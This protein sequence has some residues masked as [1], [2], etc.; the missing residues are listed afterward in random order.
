MN[1]SASYYLTEVLG[2]RWAALASSG[3][4]SSNAAPDLVT[5]SGSASMSQE[6][7]VTHPITGPVFFVYS[8]FVLNDK[9]KQ[10][11]DK[12]LAALGFA[13]AQ[14]FNSADHDSAFIKKYIE[15]TQISYAITYGINLP[16]ELKLNSLELPSVAQFIS[17][18]N[19]DQLQKL[20]RD[21]WEKL[22]QFKQNILSSKAQGEG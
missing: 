8:P 22:K 5:V 2:W 15:Q 3:D 14:F 10:I 17:T 16:T 20:K 6:A 4:V 11:V 1:E 12:M 19:A 9:E 13:G 18:Q 21:A 7:S